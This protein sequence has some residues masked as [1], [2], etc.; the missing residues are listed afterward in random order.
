MPLD[1]DCRSVEDIVSMFWRFKSCPHCRF[2]DLYKDN[3]VWHCLQCGFNGYEGG[4]LTPLS[5]TREWEEAYKIG[6][7]NTL[8][9]ALI[10]LVNGC[11]NRHDDCHLCPRTRRVRCMSMWATIG[12]ANCRNLLRTYKTLK[13]MVK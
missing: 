2:G 10:D 3:G 4:I 13:A 12:D 7:V 6:N 9:S 11:S 1:F 5:F 8:E